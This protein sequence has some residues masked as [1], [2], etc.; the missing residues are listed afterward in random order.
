MLKNKSE[1]AVFA[2]KKGKFRLRFFLGSYLHQLMIF[3][4][5]YY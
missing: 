5:L 4:K 2:I 3:M 1:K